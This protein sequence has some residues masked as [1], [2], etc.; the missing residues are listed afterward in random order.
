MTPERF[1]K[2]K[3]VLGR[4]QPDLT[5][6]TD[7]VHK[8]HNISAILRTCDAVGIHRVHAVS[9]GGDLRRHHMISGGSQRWVDVVVHTSS[10]EATS[11]LKSQGWRLVAAHPE[12][13]AKDY[14]DIDYTQK[15]AIIFG[16]ELEG[17]TPN[18]TKKVDDV[19]AIPTNGFVASLNVSV[20]AALILFE[21]RHQR[22][23]QGLYDQSR[24]SCEEFNNTLFEWA[25]PQIAERCRMRD[26]PY[27]ALT[28]DGALRT[29][30][31][32]S[33]KKVIKNNH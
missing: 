6:L 20:A 29:N 30:P 13:S 14:R 2:I 3:T 33:S 31:F 12:D 11:I 4:R 18:I 8:S 1:L 23:T 26:Q 9:S 22:E 28:Q 5:V 27:P 32:V 21:A 15:V 19:I 10:E 24:L 17:L 7:S 25:Y 16:S